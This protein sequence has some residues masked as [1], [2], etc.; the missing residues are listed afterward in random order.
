M[1]ATEY[2]RQYVSPRP[3]LPRNPVVTYNLMALFRSISSLTSYFRVHI[4]TF[5]STFCMSSTN[6]ENL[7]PDCMDLNGPII[8]GKGVVQRI[9]ESILGE[10]TF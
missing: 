7:F 6:D 2:S 5:L 1:F 10:H 4:N 3:T 8:G 9:K